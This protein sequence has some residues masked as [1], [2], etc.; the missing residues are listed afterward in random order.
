MPARQRNL[1]RRLGSDALHG[2]FALAL[3]LV[4][5]AFVA[6]L[7]VPHTELRRTMEEKTRH[8]ELLEEA[9]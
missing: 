6:T 5:L 3:V 1:P 9:A 7:F 2:A 4:G 8:R